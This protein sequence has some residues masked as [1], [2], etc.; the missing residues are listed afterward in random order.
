MAFSLLHDCFHSRRLRQ[1]SAEL[2]GV[3]RELGR[4]PAAKE[5]NRRD[6]HDGDERDEYSVLGQRS[7]FLILD[8]ALHTF[9]N[10]NHTVLQDCPMLR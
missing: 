6:C 3:L 4:N 7:T 2:V 8:E 5:G 10:A 9:S 1:P